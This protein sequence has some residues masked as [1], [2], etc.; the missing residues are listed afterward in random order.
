MHAAFSAQD[1]LKVMVEFLAG[2]WEDLVGLDV[3]LHY[4]RYRP[5][6]LDFW[7][8]LPRIGVCRHRQLRPLSNCK[9]ARF[10]ERLIRKD[11]EQPH[12]MTEEECM[13]LMHCIP[14]KFKRRYDPASK[15]QIF[16]PMGR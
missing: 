11:R 15:G 13:I 7:R 8:L 1:F 9:D 14:E 16:A 3:L 4:N 10:C 6:R 12:R 5:L 2:P